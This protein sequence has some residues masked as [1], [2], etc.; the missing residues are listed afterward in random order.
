MSNQSNVKATGFVLPYCHGGTQKDGGH[1]VLLVPAGQPAPK[2]C[3]DKV[4]LLPERP[5][6]APGEKVIWVK[7]PSVVINGQK[8]DTYGSQGSKT[9]ASAQKMIDSYLGDSFQ[10]ASKEE[11]VAMI[12]QQAANQ[13][14]ALI[15]NARKMRPDLVNVPDAE[16]LAALV[17]G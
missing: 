16:L 5:E 1:P 10:R 2:G 4:Y 17:K 3:A 11:A 15:A 13:F 14:K 9:S 7:G 12:A 6:Y 8:F